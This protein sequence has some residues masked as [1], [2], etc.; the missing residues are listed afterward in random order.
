MKFSIIQDGK[1][2][3]IGH[4]N[5]RNDLNETAVASAIREVQNRMKGIKGCDDGITVR[6]SDI[7]R[8]RYGDTI[9]LENDE[10]IVTTVYGDGTIEMRRK[11]VTE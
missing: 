4:C 1:T 7:S 10:Q 2:V 9:R 11:S 8:I 6:K 3:L 5:D